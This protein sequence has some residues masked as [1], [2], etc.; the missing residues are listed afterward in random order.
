M[1]VLQT[2]GSHSGS[3]TEARPLVL[4]VDDHRLCRETLAT[5]LCGPAGSLRVRTAPADSSLILRCLDSEQR[6]VVL[7]SCCSEVS[8]S[9]A[10]LRAI[11]ASNQKARVIVLT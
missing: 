6:A 11:R 2:I 7:L 8:R 9:L 5:A 1:H 3:P 10:L 4:V